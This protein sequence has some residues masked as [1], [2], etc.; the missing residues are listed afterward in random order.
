MYQLLFFLF[1]T[2]SL[3]SDITI[4]QFP[5]TL[6]GTTKSWFKKSIE[7]VTQDNSTFTKEYQHVYV[8]EAITK[9][10]ISIDFNSLNK[11][12]IYLLDEEEIEQNTLKSN[13]WNSYSYETSGSYFKYI[14]EQN[15][16][17]YFAL[18]IDD[19]I[20]Y[21]VSHQ[22]SQTIQHDCL[23]P[24]TIGMTDVN[25]KNEMLPDQVYKIVAKSVETEIHFYS[26]SGVSLR[27]YLSTVCGDDS[28]KITP[29]KY[30]CDD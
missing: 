23:E 28:T 21:I 18:C 20:D 2:L 9:D 24:M 10:T 17:V 3:S 12:I 15:K 29:N 5:K 26:E 25:Y 27:G 7:I 19:E 1:I 14:P 11:G 8:I 13:Q 4:T 22:T 6:E 16:S 30:Y